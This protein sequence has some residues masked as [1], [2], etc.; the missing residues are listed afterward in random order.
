[1]ET[2][3]CTK[4]KE[5]KTLENFYFRKNLN[6]YETRCRECIKK[7]KQLWEEKNKEKHKQQSKIWKQNHKEEIKQYNKEYKLKNKEK[8]DKQN[9]E[10]R[11]KNRKKCCDATKLYYKNNKQKVNERQNEYRKR[12]K[13]KDYIYKLKDQIR[14]MIN[15]SFRRNGHTKIEKTEKIIG[16]KLDYFINYLLETFKNNY[17]Y[18]WDNKEKVDIDHIIPLSKSKTE[19]D[20][21]KLCHYTNLQLLKHNDNLKKGNKLNWNLLKEEII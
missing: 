4:C 20:I 10:Y 18:E 16:C 1:M 14:K 12:R 5:D 9:Q 3:I 13:Q 6:K 11:E 8:I 2:K 15:N 21:I 19:E 17:G 7:E